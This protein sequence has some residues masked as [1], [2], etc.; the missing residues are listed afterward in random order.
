MFYLFYKNLK[1]VKEKNESIYYYYVRLFYMCNRRREKSYILVG[2]WDF[3]VKI[4]VLLIGLK[5]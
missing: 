2:I 3:L 4:N 5:G 1:F